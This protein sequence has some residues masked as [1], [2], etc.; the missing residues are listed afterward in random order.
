MQSSCMLYLSCIHDLLKNIRIPSFSLDVETST[1]FNLEKSKVNLWSKRNKYE[2]RI[3]RRSSKF[4]WHRLRSHSF[5]H[6]KML[7][8][9]WG[10]MIWSWILKFRSDYRNHFKKC[11]S[12]SL[13]QG[14]IWALNVDRWLRL[15]SQLT[16]FERTKLTAEC[17]DHYNS[18]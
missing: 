12:L 9:F 4:L 5:L 13:L 10:K 1:S 2:D 14:K 3:I 8:K 11:L 16:L 6:T 17:D 15:K 7:R 18:I